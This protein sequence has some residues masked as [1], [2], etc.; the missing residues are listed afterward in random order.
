MFY[1]V[2]CSVFAKAVL[3]AVYIALSIYHKNI[4][5]DIV[6]WMIYV[7]CFSMTV[8]MEDLFLV[9]YLSKMVSSKYQTSSEGIRRSMTRLGALLALSSSPFLFRWLEA[10]CS[11][12]IGI[13]FIMLCLLVIR[14]KTISNPTIIIT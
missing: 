5:F 4:V 10:V 3:E 11:I 2:L 9:L 14:R 1:F 13:I 7:F 8:I 6:M 12:Y